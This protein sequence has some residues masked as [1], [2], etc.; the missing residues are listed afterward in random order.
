V[1]LVKCHELLKNWQKFFI[2]SFCQRPFSFL[3]NKFAKIRAKTIGYNCLNIKKLIIFQ[4]MACLKMLIFKW[5]EC[6]YHYFHNYNIIWIHDERWLYCWHCNAR[7]KNA[8]KLNQ[9]EI[10]KRKI[11]MNVM[12][13][14]FLL[15]KFGIFGYCI[16]F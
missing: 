7:I 10:E 3:K 9:N 8:N 13:S 11:S 1:C 6:K 4:K 16:K 15:K 2:L 14:D 5:I 12:V